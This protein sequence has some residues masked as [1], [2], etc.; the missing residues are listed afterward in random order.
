MALG[1]HARLHGVG[2]VDVNTRI[3]ATYATDAGVPAKGH[4]PGQGPVREPIKQ[5]RAVNRN[6]PPA[7]FSKAGIR[8]WMNEER[9]PGVAPGKDEAWRPWHNQGAF[10]YSG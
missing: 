8:G 9:A 3:D 5:M 6:E 7:L 1:R 2:R 4:V 10:F